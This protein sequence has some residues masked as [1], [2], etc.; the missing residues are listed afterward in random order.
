[1]RVFSVFMCK[2]LVC[3]YS[4]ATVV[5]I[6][7]SEDSVLQGYDSLIGRLLTDVARDYRV[8]RV[9]KEFSR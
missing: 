8:L 1:V 5:K 4:D 2:F 6:C 9:S 3:N 7:N